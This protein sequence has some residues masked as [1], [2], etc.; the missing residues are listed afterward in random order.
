MFC[1]HECLA[2]TCSQYWR[3]PEEHFRFPGSGVTHGCEPPFIKN[4]FGKKWVC[5]SVV[6]H[7]SHSQGSGFNFKNN[8]SI[9]Y[10]LCFKLCIL[11]SIFYSDNFIYYAMFGV[12]KCLICFYF[13]FIGVLPACMSGWRCQ[14]L[15][16]WCLRPCGCWQLNSG[17]LEAQPVLF[18]CWPSLWPLIFV[19]F[20]L[21]F[22]CY[23]CFVFLRQ[24]LICISLASLELTV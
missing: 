4:S 17:F 19:G 18:N 10:K 6:E 5:S 11:Y 12:F 21:C 23:C 20:F 14:E 1:L 9:I 13:M 8:N 3:R 7:L 22:F 24:G 2:N 15:W 16:N